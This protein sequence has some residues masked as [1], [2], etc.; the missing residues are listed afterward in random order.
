M[1][2]EPTRATVGQYLDQ[3]LQDNKGNIAPNTAQT[4]A[5]FVDGHIKPAIGQIPLTTLRPEHLQR[6]YSDKLTSGRL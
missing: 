5:W 6:L 1:R 4:C 3:W 2:V